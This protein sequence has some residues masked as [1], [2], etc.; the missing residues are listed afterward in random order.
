MMRLQQ[1]KDLP[2]NARIVVFGYGQQGRNLVSILLEHYT[3]IQVSA[4]IDDAV[5]SSKSDTQPVPI[6]SSAYAA[7]HCREATHIPGCRPC[8]TPTGHRQ[9][10]CPHS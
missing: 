4:V 7:A 3:Q 9:R 8:A 5:L 6:L 1:L 2:H 10:S